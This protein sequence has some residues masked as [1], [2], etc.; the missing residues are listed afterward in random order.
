MNQEL[1]LASGSEI[2]AEMLRA[3]GVPFRVE[4]AR[5][6]ESSIRAS[7]EEE[8]ATPRDIA[9]TLA[10]YK[11]RR[12]SDRFP[13]ALVLGCD[14]TLD[15][16][17]R[18]LSKPESPEQARE[19]LQ[20]LRGN[21]HMLLSAVVGYRGSK[22]EWRH[23]GTARLW[24]RNFSDTYLDAY[25]ARNWHSIRHSVGGY[26]M[27]EEGVRLF[28]RIEG[29]HFTILGLPMFELLAFLSTRGIIET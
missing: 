25:L 11:A 19:Q 14:Q 9:D 10:E 20:A 28:S 16:D 7:L 29:D 12:V 24:M 5:I 22:P 3:A 27:E 21:R 26:K 2:R 4:V 18:C 1:I 6:D 8:G 15:F 23:V 13:E 17:G